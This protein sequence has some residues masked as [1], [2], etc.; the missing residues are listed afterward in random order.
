MPALCLCYIAVARQQE[1][2]GLTIFQEFFNGQT[3]IFVN[4]SEENGGDIS[5]RME[6]NRGAPTIGV[7]KLLVAS[8]LANF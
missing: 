5:P 4:L 3:D 8:F 2:T 7:A 6:W 1:R